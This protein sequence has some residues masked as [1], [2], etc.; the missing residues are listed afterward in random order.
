MATNVEPLL[1]SL[2]KDPRYAA[3]L[4]KIHLPA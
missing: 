3:F 1:N 2:H 4:K